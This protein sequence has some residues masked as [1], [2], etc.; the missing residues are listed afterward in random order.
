V[1]AGIS[2]EQ[3]VVD[4]IVRTL[5]AVVPQVLRVKILIAGQEVETLAGHVDLGSAFDMSGLPA[6]P[7]PPGAP[8][9]TPGKVGGLVAEP[10]SKPAGPGA[11]PAE[12]PAPANPAKPGTRR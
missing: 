7:A 4:A 10:D 1:P 11:A 6:P 8:P 12:K 5:H 9:R 3:R 2:S